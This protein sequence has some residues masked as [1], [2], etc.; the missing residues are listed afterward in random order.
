MQTKEE[1]IDEFVHVFRH[2]ARRLSNPPSLRRQLEMLYKNLRKEY[3]N[4]M[5]GYDWES[6]RDILF[7]GRELQKDN[8]MEERQV[9]LGGQKIVKVSTLQTQNV[10]GN[11][12]TNKKNKQVQ[13]ADIEVAALDNAEN[14]NFS[15]RSQGQDSNK[16][17]NAR[18]W[19]E[20]GRAHV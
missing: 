8:S 3:R 7:L 14:S 5:K 6:Y 15:K 4:Y 20:I 10:E 18:P 12:V 16:N 19:K 11:K 1:S 13:S 2:M 9:K 17:L